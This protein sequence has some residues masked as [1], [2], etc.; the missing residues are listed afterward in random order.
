MRDVVIEAATTMIV[1]VVKLIAQTHCL[2]CCKLMLETYAHLMKYVIARVIHG[3]QSFGA[4]V[5]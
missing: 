1:E 2:V 3:A 5:T 4:P